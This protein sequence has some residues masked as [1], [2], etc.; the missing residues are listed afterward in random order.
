MTIKI[1]LFDL[2]KIYNSVFRKDYVISISIL[3]FMNVYKKKNRGITIQK[4]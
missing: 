4:N 3:K 1:R 2:H